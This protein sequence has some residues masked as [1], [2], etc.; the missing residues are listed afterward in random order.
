MWLQNLGDN[1]DAK[2]QGEL[3][4]KGYAMTH[5]EQLEALA[6]GL[7]A[8]LFADGKSPM[9]EFGTNWSK[10]QMLERRN[11]GIVIKLP[12]DDGKRQACG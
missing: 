10:T 3:A 11:P 6:T 7:V 12:T 4:Q 5:N 8:S 9:E 1:A 2:S